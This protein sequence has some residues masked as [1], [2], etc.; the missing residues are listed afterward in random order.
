MTMAM[1]TAATRPRA[2]CNERTRASP[3]TPPLSA[4]RIT[5]H[6]DLSTIELATGAEPA[7]SVIW[8]H[9][10]GA[11]GDDFVPIV[12]EL[13]LKALRQATGDVRFVF[14]NAPSRPVTIN[15]G[16]VMPAW[17]DI[18]G[19]GGRAG[20]DE[21]GLRASQAAIE[22]LIERER[23]RGVPARKIVLAGF[24]QGCAM[25]LMTGLRHAEPL[26]GLMGL[27]GYLPLAAKTAAERHV[28]NRDVPI[29]MAHGTQDPMVPIER[30]EASRD[31]LQAMGYTV[32]WHA[33]PMPHSVCPEEIDDI[34]DWLVKVL[35]A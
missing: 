19:F 9:G 6:G 11:N 34:S 18:F 14:P 31:A 21:A 25:A 3:M 35:G 24:S 8:L 20:E 17:Y 1:T 30:A 29:F 10:L 22:G 4:P 7:A 28:A 26:A 33:Y 32:Q 5:R 2:H 27:S 12:P 23:T 16:Y 15:N 13:D